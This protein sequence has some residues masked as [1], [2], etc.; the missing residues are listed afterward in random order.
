MADDVSSSQVVEE[1][2]EEYQ[3]RTDRFDTL[4]NG[5]PER[6]VVERL[7]FTKK[8]IFPQECLSVPRL[9]YGFLGIEMGDNKH[10]RARLTL[11]NLDKTSFELTTDTWFSATFLSSSYIKLPNVPKYQFQDGRVSTYD[12]PRDW[13]RARLK[14]DGNTE[15][16]VYT[17]W[18]SFSTPYDSPPKVISWLTHIDCAEPPNQRLDLTVKNIS[19]TGFLLEIVSWSDS[20]LVSARVSWLAYNSSVP[21]IASGTIEKTNGWQNVNFPPGIFTKKPQ[22]WVALRKIDATPTP[23][24]PKVQV[25]YQ[26][27]TTKSVDIKCGCDDSK[28]TLWGC[29]ASWLAIE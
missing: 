24:P 16:E 22:M 19:T 25:D 21:G 17:F 15:S 9:L 7:S 20:L 14:V 28:V 27:A 1:V 11:S 18:I 13:N 6:K 2:H 10:I 8:V 12:I 5:N 29:G 4:G 3:P 23:V 26:N